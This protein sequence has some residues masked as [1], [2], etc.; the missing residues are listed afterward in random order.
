MKPFIERG[1]ICNTIKNTQKDK[2]QK[3]MISNN[4]L[5][6][7]EDLVGIHLLFER[8]TQKIH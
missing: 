5:S 1:R 7:L 8:L 3:G 6:S 2:M 4:S